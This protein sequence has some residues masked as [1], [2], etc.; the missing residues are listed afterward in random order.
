MRF[1][2]EEAMF[3]C[4][5]VA[6]SATTCLAVL[7]FALMPA[8]CTA[9]IAAARRPNIL[10]IVAENVKLD[11][12]CYGAKNVQTP[13]VDRAGRRRRALHARLRDRPGLRHQPLGVHDR[14]VSDVDR[15]APHAVASRRRLSPAGRRAA[16]DALAQGRRLLH[17]Q[18]QDDRRPRRR[19]RQARP[20]LRQ[21][22]ADLRLGPVVRA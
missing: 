17:G 16:A 15:H 7:Q 18:H 5:L 11:F 21:R 19:H 14:H 20:E 2:M 22:R 10:W 3:T 1:G 6:A 8:A 4:R 9:E 12:G 13:H